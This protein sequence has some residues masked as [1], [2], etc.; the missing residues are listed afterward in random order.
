MIL[1]TGGTGLV[2]SHLLFKLTQKG[3]K[4]RA[5]F[6]SNE[7]IEAVKHVFSYY[8]ENIESFFSKIEWVEGDIT[9]IP[10][11]TEAFK[12]ISQ[13]YHCAAFISFDPSYY[14]SLRQ[15]NI[16]GTANVVNL[17]I[18]N[19]IEKLCYVSSIAAIGNEPSNKLITEESPWNKDEDHSVYAITKYGAEMEVWRGCQE[20]LDV[21][22]VNPGVIIGPGFWRF[23]SGSFFKR[24]YKGLKYFTNGTTG[25]VSVDDV[26]KI[27]IKLMESNIKNER[28]IVVAE[29]L[30]FQSFF[31][32][33]ANALN[34]EPPKK[35][36]TPFLLQIAWRMDWLRSKLKGKHRRLVRHSV[37]S[38]Q[39]ITNYDNSK[40]K[41]DLNYEFNSVDFS[42]SSTSQYFLS[43][44]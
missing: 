44:Q 35:K 34:V 36:A 15:I 27:M 10:K 41:R 2:G 38:I 14:H 32:K 19:N 13:V 30:T 8:T 31:T 21:I 23:G 25:Y 18:S 26:T 5:L 24:I 3:H 39:S 28:Y 43:D 20:G 6:R 12:G 42:I 37:N 40:V 9:D 11:L 1:V 7:K 17:C 22:I 33:I 4:V 29:N 16:E